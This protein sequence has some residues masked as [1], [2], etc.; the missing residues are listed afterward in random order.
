MAKKETDITK[1][2]ADQLSELLGS[3][4][5]ALFFVTWLKHNRNATK[6]YME[7]HPD[8][9]ERSAATLSS[10]M[11]RKVDREVVMQ[12]Y[13]LDLN[14]YMEQLRDGLNATRFQDDGEGI[15]EVPDHKVRKE[16]HKT[17]GQL[18]GIEGQDAGVAIQ[19]NVQ[20]AMTDWQSDIY[21]EAEVV[22]EAHEEPTQQIQQP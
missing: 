7:L 19:V 3:D 5:V 6:A 12:A 11:L 21:E 20:K 18:L 16:Y 10:R 2:S 17:M 9:T 15:T 13:G 1:L 14:K 4:E 8:C 22:K